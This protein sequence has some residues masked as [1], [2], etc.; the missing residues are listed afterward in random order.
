MSNRILSGTYPFD[1]NDICNFGRTPLDCYSNPINQTA[2]QIVREKNYGV[3][4][5]SYKNYPI[6]QYH[7]LRDKPTLG[8]ILGVDF[9]SNH[10]FAAKFEPWVHEH[11]IKQWMQ[12]PDEIFSHDYVGPR[13]L[14]FYTMDTIERIS[15]LID[16]IESFGYDPVKFD[17][18]ISIDILHQDDRNRI[19]I[20]DGH[21]RVA[22]LIAL[23]QPL[24]GRIRSTKWGVSGWAAVCATVPCLT[25]KQ[26][27]TILNRYMDV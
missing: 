22:A 27:E 1:A 17:S 5:A 19:Y 25:E 24:V 12:H 26:A 4:G 15:A 13:D 8:D 23:E 6:H 18:H 9:L 10:P 11:P 2:K 16:S 14:A 3:S 7:Y 20:A 21:H